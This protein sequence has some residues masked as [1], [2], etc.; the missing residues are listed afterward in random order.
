MNK[1]R[2]LLI[3][4]IM[5]FSLHQMSCKTEQEWRSDVHELKISTKTKTAMIG[6]LFEV[7]DL[8]LGIKSRK[9]TFEGGFPYSSNNPVVNVAFSEKGLKNCR[10]DIVYDN[11]SVESLQFSVEVLEALTSEILIENLTPLGTTPIG[12]ATKFNIQSVGNPTKFK[13]TFP[14]GIPETSVEE[15]PI[16]KWNK[17][18]RVKV[19]LEV[20]REIDAATFIQEKEIFVGN[21]PLL[22]PYIP[23]DMDAWS[24]DLGA[25]IGKWTAWSEQGRDEVNFGKLEKSTSGADQT[26]NSM[27][28]NYNKANES[29]Q[30]F[31]RDNWTNNAQLQKGK[32]YEFVF[33]MKADANFILSEVILINNLPDWSW[34]NIL[35][36]HSKNNW[37]QYFPSIPFEVQ[38][39][40]RLLY[41]SNLAIT[42]EW[43]KFRYEFTV[44]NSDIQNI[45]LPARLLNTYPFFVIN[46]VAPTTIHIDE[47]QINLIEN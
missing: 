20:T 22:Q 2:L 23:A 26:L 11:G 3:V 21:Y 38:N 24:F 36:A 46:S 10:L 32:T 47:V 12:K 30:L 14:G 40:T 16:V 19:K 1:P 25:K 42:T 31:T 7:T 9:W 44:G 6:Q 27:R 17:R 35:Q 13:W 4:C 41:D 18:G 5:L 37:S 15:S 33:W 43:K 39:E 8:S 45:P 34:N 29:W 28:I